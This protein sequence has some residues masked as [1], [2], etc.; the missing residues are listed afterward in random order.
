MTVHR[1]VGDVHGDFGRYFELVENMRSIQI[2]DFGVGFG[3]QYWHDMAN[4]YHTANPESRFIRGN[5]DDPFRCKEQMVGY[6]SDGTIEMFGNT[7]VMFIGGAWSIDYAR[8][9]EGVSWW[10]DEELS[11]AELNTMI[12]LYEKEKPDVMI[13]HDCPISVSDEMFIKTGLALGGR[14]AKQ[15][16]NKTNTALQTM[17]EI[18]QPKFWVFGHWHVPTQADINGTHFH[19]INRVDKETSE[20]IIVGEYVDF[21]FEKMEYVK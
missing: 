6:I 12:D 14:Q 4:D 15:I 17:F 13:T 19:C 1:L 8:R 9:V 5:H 7:K 3:A 11:V 18:H 2:G 16:P 20:T 21:D 10:R